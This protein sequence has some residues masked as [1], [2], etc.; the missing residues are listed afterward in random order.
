MPRLVGVDETTMRD[1]S[2]CWANGSLKKSTPGL[3][4]ACRGRMYYRYARTKFYFPI[5]SQVHDVL[6]VELRFLS[7][8]KTNRWGVHVPVKAAV[9][10][11]LTGRI[12]WFLDGGFSGQGGHR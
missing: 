6:E 12:R 8:H 9:G 7:S 11:V 1:A 3:L 5:T 10:P 4:P 2:C